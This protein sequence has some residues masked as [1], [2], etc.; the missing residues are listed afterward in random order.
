MPM[1]VFITTVRGK[2]YPKGKDFAGPRLIAPSFTAAEGMLDEL[3]ESGEYPLNLA[4]TGK[5][6]GEMPNDETGSD[7]ERDV[8]SPYQ[9]A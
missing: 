9:D 7:S 1:Y 5:L 2:D 3:V 8:D 4:I 6:H